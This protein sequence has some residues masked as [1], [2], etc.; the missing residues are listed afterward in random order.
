MSDS[1]ATIAKARVQMPAN[2]MG[3]ALSEILNFAIKLG[4]YTSPCWASP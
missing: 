3:N 2:F 1:D 4:K